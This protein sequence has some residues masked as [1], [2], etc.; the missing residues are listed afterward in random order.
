MTHLL[1]ALK[2][3]CYQKL[4]TRQADAH[5]LV[6]FREAEWERIGDTERAT[7]AV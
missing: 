7:R 2:G 5:A 4:D 1:A 3:L 6:L